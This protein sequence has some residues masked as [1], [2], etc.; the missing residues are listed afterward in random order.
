MSPRM[1]YLR[2][3][4]CDTSNKDRSVI[5]FSRLRMVSTVCR[6]LMIGILLPPNRSGRNNNVWLNLSVQIAVNVICVLINDL[7]LG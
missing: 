3:R 1:I 2:I 5:A 4:G 7:Q 6:V